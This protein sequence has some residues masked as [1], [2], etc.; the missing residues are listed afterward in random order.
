M[1]GYDTH[2][3]FVQNIYMH[4]VTF[5]VAIKEGKPEVLFVS[6][7]MLDGPKRNIITDLKKQISVIV[8]DECH[9]IPEW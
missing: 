4:V 5:S 2:T 3:V 7:E 8:F 6:P 9:V 1:Y